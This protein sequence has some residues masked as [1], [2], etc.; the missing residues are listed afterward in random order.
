MKDSD[1]EGQA[2]PEGDAQ[3]KKKINPS[4]ALTAL[5]KKAGKTV[6]DLSQVHTLQDLD[7]FLSG[8]PTRTLANAVDR[9]S[10]ARPPHNNH[11]DVDPMSGDNIRRPLEALLSEW[12]YRKQAMNITLPSGDLSDVAK[13]ITIKL[14]LYFSLI[15]MRY[16]SIPKVEEMASAL[17][18]AN[19]GASDDEIDDITNLYSQS[20]KSF[21]Q[22]Q[23]IA[24]LLRETLVKRLGISKLEKFDVIRVASAYAKWARAARKGSLIP[25][26]QANVIAELKE[27]AVLDQYLNLSSMLLYGVPQP[28]YVAMP[29]LETVLPLTSGGDEKGHALTKIDHTSKGF[30]T[31]NPFGT[32]RR[33]AEVLSI[34]GK[35]VIVKDEFTPTINTMGLNEVAYCLALLAELNGLSLKETIDLH[36]MSRYPT[37]SGVILADDVMDQASRE[38][39]D[40]LHDM[41]YLQFFAM[42]T[43]SIP[44]TNEVAGIFAEPNRSDLHTGAVDRLPLASLCSRATVTVLNELL[45]VAEQSTEFFGSDLSE[46]IKMVGGSPVLAEEEA[47]MLKLRRTYHAGRAT[48]VIA[49]KRIVNQTIFVDE[50]V[51][52]IHPGLLDIME[53]TDRAGLLTKCSH[54][55]YFKRPLITRAENDLACI[56]SNPKLINSD[57]YTYDRLNVMSERELLEATS[58]NINYSKDLMYKLIART[59]GN[60]A[61]SRKDPDSPSEELVVVARVEPT[62]YVELNVSALAKF[63]YQV[64]VIDAV[65]FD[66]SSILHHSIRHDGL[67]NV[68]STE[69]SAGI[70][71]YD[72][73]ALDLT[74]Y[75]FSPVLKKTLNRLFQQW[76]TAGI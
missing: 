2:S 61:S 24:P 71:V 34:T 26:L 15:A 4:K 22:R 16:N 41:I 62:L 48:S 1:K 70:E 53:K 55:L 5:K 59:R 42:M 6:T 17:A 21:M 50:N 18:A 64:E 49:D 73:E 30:V 51:G 57:L 38:F 65:D 74:A 58:D 67:V 25:V 27:F 39:V 63:R 23:I 54:K 72:S 29:V 28:M 46:V 11:V 13:G 43:N 56:F 69:E 76:S 75:S 68:M 37:W 31:H 20:V 32:T 19:L 45:A 35:P 60:A 40:S 12:A 8:N 7:A 10:S 66:L 52:L 36:W 3:G 33:A 14:N 9:V 47:R 44:A